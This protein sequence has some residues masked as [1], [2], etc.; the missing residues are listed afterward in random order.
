MLLVL[1]TWGS[2]DTRKN[3]N[4]TE[5]MSGITGVRLKG[6]LACNFFPIYKSIIK[7]LCSLVD[8]SRDIAASYHIV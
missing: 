2:Y 6:L 5:R 4:G 1:I 3:K 8:I 7:W